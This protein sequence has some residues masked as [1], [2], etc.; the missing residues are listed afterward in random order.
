MR[1]VQG[2]NRAL[3]ALFVLTASL[4]LAAQR[5]AQAA[6]IPDRPE[7]LKYPELKFNIPKADQYRFKL[8]N[9]IVAYVAED[10]SLP[11]VTV[12]V[13][14]KAGSFLEP[15]DRT[16]LASLTGTMM[17][18][19]GAG[20]LTAEEFDEK[21]DFL[22]ADVSSFI[23]D[24]QAGASVNCLASALD[25]SLDLFFEMMRAP[26]FQQ[27]RLDVEKSDLIEDMKQ[28]NDD[29]GTILNREWGWQMYGRTHFS[30]RQATKAM[31]ESLTRDSL[32]DFHKAYWRPE[33]MIISVA[34]DVNT[35]EILANLERR[36]AD[37]K[38]QGPVVPW[39]PPAPDYAP[40][41]GLFYVEKDIP[42]G[43][44]YIGNR[45]T[46]WNRWDDP[47]NYALLVMNDILGGGGFTSRITKKVRSDEGLA[48][49]A[50]S[51]YN[52]GTYYPLDYRISFQSKSSTVALAGKLSLVEVAK[53]KDDN[54][55]E[56]ELKTSKAS[57]IDTFPR[58]FESPARVVSLFA[59]DDYIGRP[60]SY[61]D[62]YRANIQKVTPDEVKRVAKKYLAD[63]DNVVFL[64]VGKR[65]EIEKGDPDGRASM[66]EFFGG[67]AT[68]LPL[69]DPLTL[70]PMK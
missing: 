33:N 25:K 56:D 51:R 28:R 13:I 1:H 31:I 11:L 23:G 24:T 55:S 16:G 59:T 38:V 19:G 44:V 3:I 21:A 52:I 50:G 34:G 48:Y 9:G 29:A 5:P 46:K 63:K 6:G 49:S 68:Q 45:S 10:H 40:K 12:S 30:S 7:S 36:F 22:A 35:K 43:K 17:R 70:Q 2:I 65:S 69:L 18:K 62:N 27:S 39:P 32:V 20:S 57:F 47:D 60:H 41:P 54:V 26:R 61:W 42:Q 8:K 37:W 53:L 64:V 58:N 15:A 66:K 4:L 14:V 67:K